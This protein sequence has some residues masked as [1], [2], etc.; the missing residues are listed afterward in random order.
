[1]AS[2]TAAAAAASRVHFARISDMLCILT[3]QARYGMA[4]GNTGSGEMWL[5]NPNGV[6]LSLKAKRQGLAV[7]L[8]ADAVIIDFK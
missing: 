4:A 3:R 6:M 8:G 7:S 5:E 2:A 1:M